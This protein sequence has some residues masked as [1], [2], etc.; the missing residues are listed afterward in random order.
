M[1]INS[2]LNGFIITWMLHQI[3]MLSNKV[4]LAAGF[5]NLPPYPPLQLVE[6][7]DQ[8][9]D[10]FYPEIISTYILYPF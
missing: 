9:D 2:S 6:Q 1:L 3:F 8:N 10:N 7:N 4:K 5:N